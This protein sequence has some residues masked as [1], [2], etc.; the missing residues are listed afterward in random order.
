MLDMHIDENYDVIVAGSGPAGIGAA[1]AAA[2]S[3]VKTLIL[4]SRGFPGG[5]STV[6]PWMPINRMLLNGGTRG[7]SHEILVAEIKKLGKIASCSGRVNMIDGDGLNC[8]P[9]YLEL[10][11]YNAFENNGVDYLLN[12]PVI[13]AIKSENKVIGVV[14]QQQS[15]LLKLYADV[16][17][18]ATGDGD[19]AA[20]AGADFDE[21]RVE[22]GRHMPVALGFMVSGID[23]D[24]I[25]KW[26]KKDDNGKKILEKAE[27]DGYKLA[28]WYGFNKST[29]PNVVG[30]NN[31]GYKH[32]PNL[33]TLECTH[34]TYAR[35]IGLQIAIDFIEILNNNDIDGV[36]EA[37]LLSVG[38]D[39]GIRDTRRIKGEYTQTLQDAEQGT[40]FDDYVA[41][42]YGAVDAN[43]LYI[44]KMSSGYGYPYR[45]MIAK[46]IDGLLLAG[47]CGSATLLGH[48][49]GKSMG[50]MMDLGQAAGVAASIA[51]KSNRTIRQVTAEEIRNV[52]RSRNVT[53]DIKSKRRVK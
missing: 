3:G 32:A 48:A 2:Q 45:S 42:K 51:S 46:G 11:I 40:F 43:Q 19:V 33:S 22:D 44:G 47:R 38:A 49:A 39:L 14:V 9:A 52:L 20:A 31:G 50:N 4:E 53:L 36:D 30:V 29:I 34:Y 25:V 7:G 17:I 21:G 1:L 24:R 27:Q 10:A 13:D 23:Y 12:A 8:H 37:Y 18:D 41:R 15:G 26:W 5:V 16:V 6:S 35:R 28:A